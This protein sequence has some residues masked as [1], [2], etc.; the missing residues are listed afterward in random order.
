M[1]VTALALVAALTLTACGTTRLN[2]A[3]P[4]AAQAASARM[5][6]KPQAPT[7]LPVGATVPA[8]PM[9]ALDG[10]ADALESYR[11]KPVVL[12]FWATWCPS[13]TNELPHIEALHVDLAAQGLQVL[14]VN[15]SNEKLER[16]RD[17]IA[18]QQYT[19][20][21]FGQYTG[22]VG[23]DFKCNSIPTVYFVGRDGVIQDVNVGEIDPA[24]LRARAK[25]LL[26][27][28]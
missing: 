26:A 21:V 27:S 12:V 8:L 10:S 22:A 1:R 6:L 17:F 23:R 3:A 14:A 28:T 13:C 15:A 20:P 4:K 11:G 2:P 9:T 25:K 24:D 16:L 18:W 7:H 19:F 5:S